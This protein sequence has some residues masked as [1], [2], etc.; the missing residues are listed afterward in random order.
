MQGSAG[1]CRGAGSGGIVWTALAIR[2]LSNPSV[3]SPEWGRVSRSKLRI[4]NRFWREVRGIGRISE[5]AAFARFLVETVRLLPAVLRARSLAPV[6][7]RMARRD[8]HRFTVFGADLRVPGWAFAGAREMYGRRPYFQ[9][10][11]LGFGQGD[12]VVDL[13]ANA[14]LFTLLAAKLG[15]R[16]LAVEAQSGF[17][18]LA[19]QNLERNGCLDHVV[20]VHGL[21][22][23]SKGLFGDAHNLRGASH[24]EIEPP[25]RDVA[26]IL[27]PFGDTRV[28]FLKMDIE[29]SEF[30]VITEEASWLDRVERISMEVHPEH[31]EPASLVRVLSR[32]GFEVRLLDNDM[33]DVTAVPEVGGYLLAARRR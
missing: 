19:R 5:P 8:E 22:G 16:V 15:A 6:D 30:G 33:R 1:V 10:A 9:H 14:G 13:G 23:G 17:L 29:G 31:G 7:E 25:V 2:R 26:G 32:R 20:L 24:F 27:E 28:A 12:L 11:D 4:A 18:S 3:G 21:V